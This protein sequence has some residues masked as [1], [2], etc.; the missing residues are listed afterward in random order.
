MW[1]PETQ[2]CAICSSAKIRPWK[3]ISGR[4]LARCGACGLGFLDAPPT[5]QEMAHLYDEPYFHSVCVETK[6]RAE[7]SAAGRIALVERFKTP[8]ALLDVGCGTGGFL[9]EA[10]RRGWEVKGIEVSTWAAE[11]ARRRLGVNV[12]A[13]S[14][15]EA[16]FPEGTFDVVTFW[17]A[18]EH[19]SQPGT[20]LRRCRRWLKPDGVLVIRIVNCGSYDAR[21]LGMRWSGW[22]VPYHLFHFSPDSLRAALRAAGFDVVHLDAGVSTVFFRFL[23]APIAFPPHHAKLIRAVEKC[24]PRLCER[25]RRFADGD[26]WPGP[27]LRRIF[28]GPVMDIVARR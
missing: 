20:V 7:H 16:D 25:V 21:V 2:I 23:I 10:A 14:A 11:E 5:P 27:L 15:T 12:I 3:V 26:D 17:D 4:R 9:A 28:P 24:C 19:L 13:K 18:L 6:S 1:T 22:A 8:G